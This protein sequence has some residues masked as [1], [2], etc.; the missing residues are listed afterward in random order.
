MIDECKV[1]VVQH[2]VKKGN[3]VAHLL[4]ASICSNKIIKIDKIMLKIVRHE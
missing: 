4:S 2:Y 1:N 3:N